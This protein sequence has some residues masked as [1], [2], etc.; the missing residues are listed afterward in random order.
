MTKKV[1]K[2]KP[3]TCKKGHKKDNKIG[4]ACT[5]GPKELKRFK[6][7]WDREDCPAGEIVSRDC[8]VDKLKFDNA[9]NEGTVRF[10]D[11]MRREQASAR[12]AYQANFRYS[13][14]SWQRTV[15]D[16]WRLGTSVVVYPGYR[17]R[18]C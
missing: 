16:V 7:G 1:G 10:F 5:W 2:K 14:R 13:S 6:I 8:L 4:S 11:L 9:F 15:A 3:L 17:R 12:G 18:R